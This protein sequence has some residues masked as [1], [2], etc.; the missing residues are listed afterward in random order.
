MRYRVKAEHPRRP[1]PLRIY[2]NKGHFLAESGQ[3]CDHLTAEH[4]ASML[5]NGYL[6]PIGDDTT[7]VAD[8]TG[9][10]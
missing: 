10:P 3:T 1:Q 5:A 4:I 2:D 9:E 7:P 8:A 6:E